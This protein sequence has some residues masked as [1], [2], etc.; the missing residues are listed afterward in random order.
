[1]ATKYSEDPYD[2]LKASQDLVHQ[3]L[4]KTLYDHQGHY[5]IDCLLDVAVGLGKG[6]TQAAEQFNV[7]KFIGNDYSQVMLKHAQKNFPNFKPIHGNCID[8]D[9]QVN[10]KSVDVVYA[11]YVLSYV[12]ALKLF[13]SI[14]KVLKPGGY[15]SIATSTWENLRDCQELIQQE[16]PLLFNRDK[17]IK[18]YNGMIPLNAEH[19]QQILQQ[20][21]FDNFVVGHVKKEIAFS[22]FNMFWA[23]FA[24]AGWH[25]QASRITGNTKIDKT[26]WRIKIA[27][28]HVF[29]KKLRFPVSF[30]TNL[31]VITAQKPSAPL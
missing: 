18:Q 3:Q 30:T 7:K 20:S 29:S 26:L 14:Y 10:A 16:L 17:Y 9:K 15:I 22:S 6:F 25:V 11:H 23:Y 21:G 2:L 5:H 27:L 8:I 31:C 19:V 24:E 12:N 1:M 28:L 4:A 13:E